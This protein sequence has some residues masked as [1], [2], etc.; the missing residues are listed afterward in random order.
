LTR[1]IVRRLIRS[2][3]ARKLP[4]FDDSAIFLFQVV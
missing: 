3:V 1:K 2:N 4:R